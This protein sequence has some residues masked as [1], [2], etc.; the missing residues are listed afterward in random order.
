MPKRAFPDCCCQC[1]CPCSEPV[2]TYASIGGPPTLPGSG[3]SVLCG[4]SAPFFWVLVR[5]RFCLCPPWLESLFTPALRKSYN[6]IL[7]ALNVRFPGD[8]QS[9]FQIPR[10]GSLAWGS[11]PWR[12]WENVFG[13]LVL[14]FVG[15]PPGRYGIW[16]Y[17]D[18]APP[19]TVLLWLLCL[20]TW[21]TFFWWVLASS[22]QWL[23]NS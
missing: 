3:G 10:L 7:L 16:F 19:T 11:E 12:Q 5:A 2:L 15:H 1:P 18:S 6:P 22:Y 20:W 9:L 17:C 8:S 21:V 13:I 14:Q 4:V 23:F